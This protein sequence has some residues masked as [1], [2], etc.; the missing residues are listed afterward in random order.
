MIAVIGDVHGQYDPLCRLERRLPE[1]A[2]RIFVGDLFDRGPNSREVYEHLQDRPHQRVMGN[3][4]Q[5]LLDVLSGI[6]PD[7]DPDDWLELYGGQATMDSFGGRFEP[8]FVAFLATTPLF[9]ETEGLLVVHAGIAPGIPLEQQRREDLLWIR[10]E[11]Y[12][13][14]DHGYPGTVVFGHTPFPKVFRGRRRVGCDTGAGQGERL[15]AVLFE[16]G[17]YVGSLSEPVDR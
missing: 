2:V 12:L 3:H 5:Q 8:L 1:D 6:E 7:M 14:A 13:A 15:S 16:G 17:K 10:E 11:F 9:L 4:D